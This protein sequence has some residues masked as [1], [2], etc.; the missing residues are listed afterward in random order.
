MSTFFASCYDAFTDQ[1]KDEMRV[2]KMLQL[3]SDELLL[4]AYHHALRLQL[5]KEF[6]YMLLSEIR[7]RKLK[8]SEAQ[9]G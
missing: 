1:S 7:L 8:L 3:L 5:E 2:L 9:A 4:E 6:V